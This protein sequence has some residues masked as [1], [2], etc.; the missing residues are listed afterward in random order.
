MENKL[1]GN[2]FLSSDWHLGHANIAGPATSKWE[3]GSHRGFSSIEEMDD[4]IIRNINHMV[5][6]D[7]IIMFHGDFS[8]GG[9]HKVPDYRRRINCQNIHFI[10]GNHDQ[11]IDKYK[12][13]FTS[14]QNYWEGSL[15]GLPF[16]LLHYAL[17]IWLGSHKGF[18]HTYGHSHSS[19]ERVPYGKSMDVGI[20]NAFKLTGEYRPFSLDEVVKILDKR[21]V[22]MVDNH[23]KNTNV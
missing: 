5:P 4:T 20:D 18:Y 19:L 11:H 7:G 10:K 16:V 9:H 2:I 23:G 12:D 14:I 6:E 21:E 13:F 1:R 15:N 8:F 17:R 22:K 3:E